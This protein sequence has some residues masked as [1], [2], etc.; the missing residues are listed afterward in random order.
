ML[1]RSDS[2]PGE[3]W[4]YL[5]NTRR[6]TGERTRREISIGDQVRVRLDHIDAMEKRMVFSLAGPWAR[7]SGRKRPQARFR[8]R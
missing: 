4:N 6:I 7:E 8:R 3:R 5:E 2:L 1:F